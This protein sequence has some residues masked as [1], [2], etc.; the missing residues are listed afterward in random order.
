MRRILIGLMVLWA[1]VASVAYGATDGQITQYIGNIPTAVDSGITFTDGIPTFTGRVDIASSDRITIIGDSYSASSFALINKAYISKLSLFSDYNF[2]NF[3]L[4]GSTAATRLSSILAGDTL[5]HDSLTYTDYTTKYALIAVYSNDFATGSTVE[6]YLDNIV[7]LGNAVQSMGA[8]PILATEHH[9]AYGDFIASQVK[10]IADSNGWLYLNSQPFQLAISRGNMNYWEGGHP[11]T[12]TNDIIAETYKY[13][14]DQLPTPMQSLKIFRVRETPSSL[15]E[16]VF[17]DNE[18]RAELWQEIGVGQMT[19]TNPEYYDHID[20]SDTSDDFHS[21]DSEYLELQNNEVVTL[22]DYA[23][24]SAT[25]PMTSSNLNEIKLNVTDTGVAV[26]VLDSFNA[27]TPTWVAITCDDGV[28]TVSG[29]TIQGKMRGDKIDFLLVDTSNGISLANPYVEYTGTRTKQFPSKPF[30]SGP[31]FANSAE[32]L[33]YTDFEIGGVWDETGTV[34]ESPPADGDMPMGLVNKIDVDDSNYVTQTLTYASNTEDQVVQ[35]AVWAR[36]FPD[37]CPSSSYPSCDITETSYDYKTLRVFFTGEDDGDMSEPVGGNKTILTGRVG[38]AWKKLFW[39]VTLPAGTTTRNITVKADSEL[40]I[41]SVSVK[42]ISQLEIPTESSLGVDDLKTLSGMPGG[43]EDLGDFDTGSV[44]SNNTTIKDALI[45]VDVAISGLDGGH[46][47]NT[48]TGTDSDDFAIGGGADVDISITANNG[49]ANAPK[50]IYASATSSWQYSNDG[51]DFFD[52]G[53]NG[54][55]ISFG[56]T[57]GQ[58]PYVNATLDD[59]LYSTTALTIDNTNDSVGIG[60]APSAS[61]KLDVK[62]PGDQLSTIRVYT[63]ATVTAN[64]S[65]IAASYT[66]SSSTTDN[67]G[68][69]NFTAWYTPT[70]G[71]ASGDISGLYAMGRTD[72]TGGDITG[73]IIGVKARG[74]Y[75]GNKNLSSLYGV[76]ADTYSGGGVTIRAYGLYYSP[77]VDAGNITNAYG[78]YIDAQQVG[79]GTVLNSTG[80]Y[81]EDLNAKGGDDIPSV[82]A[83][84]IQTFNDVRHGSMSGTYGNGSAYVCVTNDGLLFASETA[85]P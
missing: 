83:V 15:M 56:S 71:A 1:G 45:E 58:V 47:Q 29:T 6:S 24:I 70:T 8:T 48:D 14:L 32:L 85:C 26:Y 66:H 19:L 72:Y 67:T 75:S 13:F 65:S 35:L 76:K 79:T 18:S 46:D 11:G 30:I 16:L 23:I 37:Q 60:G 64:G 12:R 68:A 2:E 31:V 10:V 62:G 43:S 78:V 81:V 3:S 36:N 41:A 21:L 4:G 82:S 50:F 9:T 27:T 38:L 40:E 22:G 73:S 74:N 17:S 61:Y 80:I 7:A 55:N 5:Y 42:L 52:I 39:N 28:C 25:L 20:D 84:S 49:D 33:S 44:I 54:T 53:S 51:V 63:P 57:A 59:F 69:G 77:K 34:T